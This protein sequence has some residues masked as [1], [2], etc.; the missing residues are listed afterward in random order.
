MAPCSSRSQATPLTHAREAFERGAV[1]EL[2]WLRAGLLDGLG[3]G[4][5]RACQRTVFDHQAQGCVFVQLTSSPLQVS[6]LFVCTLLSA[7]VYSSKHR[8]LLYIPPCCLTHVYQ[9]LMLTLS[10]LLPLLQPFAVLLQL[11]RAV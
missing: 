11:A 1:W 5:G 9:H 3:C 7:C 2:C 10:W 4:M 6:T 8:A